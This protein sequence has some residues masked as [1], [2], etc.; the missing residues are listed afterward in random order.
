[1]AQHQR[2]LSKVVES[3]RR[4]DETEPRH[5][6]RLSPEMA[7]IGVEGLGA[8]DGEKDGAEGQEAD[9]AVAG[10]EDDCIVR[11]EGGEHQWVVEDM[12]EAKK[13]DCDEP[14]ARDRA[15]E[16][17][18]LRRPAR[19]DDEEGDENE[20]RQRQDEAVEARRRDLEALDGGEHRKSRRD[21]RVA[22]EERG[23]DDCQQKHDAAGA[24]EGALRQRGES[25][26]PAFAVVV[27][28]GEDEDVFDRHDED[29][30]PQDQRQ[31]AEHGRLGDRP[32]MARCRQHRLAERVERARADVAI[33]DA[34]AADGQRPEDW[35]SDWCGHPV[36][37]CRRIRRARH[38]IG[39][40]L[41]RCCTAICAE[42]GV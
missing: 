18:D 30:G 41:S 14:D 36:G 40:D 38:R 16:E 22:V 24:A 29:Q 34:D 42:A 31:H 5:L 33:D 6:N 15:E 13:R 21:D 28:P 2:A 4:Q 8:G 39:H 25:Q 1:M 11:A 7:E 20:D 26:R 32:A 37:V 19:L 3:E 12:H 17:R 9:E 35:T 10:Q 27:R 23:R